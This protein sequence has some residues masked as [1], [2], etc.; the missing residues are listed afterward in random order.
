MFSEIHKTC[1]LSTDILADLGFPKAPKKGNAKASA[2]KHF[3]KGCSHLCV[4]W[5]A[6]ASSMF[7]MSG[8]HL[9]GWLEVYFLAVFLVKHSRR[10]ICSCNNCCVGFVGYR[11]FCNKAICYKYTLLLVH[12]IL[13]SIKVPAQLEL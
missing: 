13:Y 2:C 5:H 8:W 4:V 12:H 7:S 3:A 6:T 9:A 10:F 11:K 1:L